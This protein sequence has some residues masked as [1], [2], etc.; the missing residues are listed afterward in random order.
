MQRE[1]GSMQWRQRCVE[2]FCSVPPWLRRTKVGEV[3]GQS[4]VLGP[5]MG[6]IRTAD[7]DLRTEDRGLRTDDRGLSRAAYCGDEGMDRCFG[8]AVDRGGG[9]AA[10]GWR[11]ARL[12]PDEPKRARRA[13]GGGAGAQGRAR[14]LP[15][16][17]VT[18]LRPAVGRTSGS[19]A[20]LSGGAVLCDQQGPAGGESRSGAEDRG[21]Q[22]GG[23]R[24]RA[25]VRSA[26]VDDRP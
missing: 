7:S 3:T 9:A 6:E 13:V 14:V 19:G 16:V 10:R 8:V 5:Q 17:L 4:S 15:R 21:G 11:G 2:S 20:E 18:V 22:A 25:V 1:R 26:V 23:A 12:S 24:V